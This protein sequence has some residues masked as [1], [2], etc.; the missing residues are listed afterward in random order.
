LCKKYTKG[1]KR[2]TRNTTNVDAAK[3]FDFMPMLFFALLSC[4]AFAKQA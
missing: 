3:M 2:K 4:L 1:N